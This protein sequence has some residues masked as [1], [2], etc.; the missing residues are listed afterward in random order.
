MKSNNAEVLLEELNGKFDFMIEAMGQMQGQINR[1]PE[2]EEFDDL[3]ADVKIIKAA[4]TINTR[5]I[6]NHEKR[7]T[8]L[9]SKAA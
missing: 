5:D 2:R 9:E 7:I 8:K 1:L 3:K 4:A 6:A